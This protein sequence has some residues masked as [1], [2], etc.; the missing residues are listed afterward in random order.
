VFTAF[1]KSLSDRNIYLSLKDD[2][3]SLAFKEKENSLLGEK[4]E[5]FSAL[6]NELTEI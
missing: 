5:T 1:K 4:D 3:I 6:Y 2:F